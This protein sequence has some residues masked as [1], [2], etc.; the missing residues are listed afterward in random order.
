M[1]RQ[2]GFQEGVQS[3][4]IVVRINMKTKIDRIPE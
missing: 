4:S 3:A 2:L 1:P